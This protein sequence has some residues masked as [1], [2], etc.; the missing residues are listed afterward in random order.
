MYTRGKGEHNV[1][2]KYYIYFNIHKKCYSVKLRGKVIQHFDNAVVAV[3]EFRVSAAG[4]ERV[5][6][7]QKKAVHAYIVT[8]DIVFLQLAAPA[9]RQFLVACGLQ[10]FVAI[11]KTAHY[12]PYKNE[13]F[14]DNDGNALYN[15]HRAY[16]SIVNGKPAIEIV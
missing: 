2:A 14:V 12:N 11:K 10:A 3:P 13:S 9:F 8:D 1:N 4:R 16:L 15:A 6:R 5:R 7:E